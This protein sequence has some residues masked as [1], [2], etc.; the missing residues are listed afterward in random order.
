M[1]YTEVFGKTL[2]QLAKDDKKIV[3]IT[4]AMPDGTG[5][6]YFADA[7]PDRFFDVGIAEQH[8]VTSA[9]GMA[10]AGLHPVV[11]VYSTFL[12][13]AYDSVLHDIAMQNLPVVL[14][15]DRAGLVGDDGYTHHGV[16]DFSY[17]RL[18]P[19]ITIMAPKDENEFRHM[20]ATAVKFNGP[21]ALRYPRGSGLGVDI[22]EPLHTLPIGK[23]EELKQG[24]DV[25]I[26]AVGSMVDEAMKAAAALE[27]D[28]ISA[29][30][31]N[32]RFVK[33]FDSELLVKTAQQYKNIVT[34]EEGSLKGG[35]GSAVLEV[36]NEN[37]MLQSVKV[38]NLGIP[39]KYIPHGAKPELM[40]DIGL[41]HES[42]VKRIKEFLN[43][44]D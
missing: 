8:A 44:G 23:A 1:S 24:S 37:S 42:V 40:R 34:M 36:L 30:V 12:Q 21:V 26:W 19:Q 9:A 39:D 41:D 28:G 2:V 16:F 5:L 25:C 7:Y 11:A 35:A 6:N 33:P 31:V 13:R 4:A 10:A 38:L 32:M 43:N 15:L 18:I 17:L 3:A 27:E 22:S 14:G 20:L 29:G